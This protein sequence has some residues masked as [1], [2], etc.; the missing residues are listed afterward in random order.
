MDSMS[1]PWRMTYI[2]S[3]KT[4]TCVFCDGTAARENLVLYKGKRAFVMLNLYPYISGHLMII[5]RRHIS[6]ME[7]LSREEKIEI[8]DLLDLSVR[9]LKEAMKPDGFNIG[10]NMGIAAGAGIDDH[11]HVHVVPRWIGDTNFMSVVGEVRVIPEDIMKTGEQ[12]K[13]YFNKHYQED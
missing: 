1:A 7:D 3:E 4:D 12:L 9:V 13:P 6:R 11:L 10:I 8:F 2:R 5:P